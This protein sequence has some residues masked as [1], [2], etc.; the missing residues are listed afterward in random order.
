MAWLDGE[1]GTEEIYAGDGGPTATG[2]G[3][4]VAGNFWALLVSSRAVRFPGRCLCVLPAMWRQR[5]WCYTTLATTFLVS[6]WFSS[7]LPYVPVA[8]RTSL[9]APAALCDFHWV[10]VDDMFVF[11]VMIVCTYV[12]G[13]LAQW[14]VRGGASWQTRVW[15]LCG[16]NYFESVVHTL[17]N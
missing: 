15:I 17:L 5:W 16:R 2:E 4:L 12:D 10:V 13:L 8:V 14:Q 7:V 6:Y 3:R 9:W 1:D 11:L